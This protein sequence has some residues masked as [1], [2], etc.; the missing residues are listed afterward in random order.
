MIFTRCQIGIDPK[1]PEL[2]KINSIDSVQVKAWRPKR[3]VDFAGRAWRA[4]KRRKGRKEF[5]YSCEREKERKSV[6][7]NKLTWPYI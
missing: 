2:D 5:G 4:I 6:R 3:N 7:L 1:D